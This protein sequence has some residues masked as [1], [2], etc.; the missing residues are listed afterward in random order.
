MQPLDVGLFGPMKQLWGTKL[1]NAR[2]QDPKANLLAKSIFPRMVKEL[3]ETLNVAAHMPST[4]RKCGLFPI[5]PSQ[6]LDRLPSKEK[7]LNIYSTL[8][9]VLLDRLE[10]R[11]F[12]TPVRK[13]RGKKIPAGQS[14]RYCQ[15]RL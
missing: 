5:D 14:Y 13:P 6:V 9:Q 11:R 4:F 8:D 3:V 12:S 7:S 2:D 15:F 1:H 10:T